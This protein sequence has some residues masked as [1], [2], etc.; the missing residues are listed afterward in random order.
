MCVRFGLEGGGGGGG[1]GGGTVG[2][3]GKLCVP[4]ENSWLRAWVEICSPSFSP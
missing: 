4:L 2:G 3:Y 1:G